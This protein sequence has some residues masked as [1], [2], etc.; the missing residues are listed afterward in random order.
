M[1]PADIEARIERARALMRACTLCERRCG[2]D[3]LAGERGYCGLGAEARLVRELLHFGEELEL[4]PSHAIYL[5]GCSFRCVFC[6]S[7][8]VVL[9]QAAPRCG[10]ALEPQRFAQV[11]AARRAQGARNVNFLGG[12][13]SVNLL[14]VLELLRHCPPDTRVVWNSNMYYTP[15]QAELLDGVV[16]VYLGDWKFGNDACAMRLAAVP[17][18]TQV[19]RRNFERALVSGARVIA[20]YLVMPG[21]ERC[22]LEPICRMLAQQLPGVALS[23]LDPYLPLFRAGRVPGMDRASTP[24]EGERARALAA[25]YG[26][27]VVR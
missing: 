11:V 26:L 5:S 13:P 14:A 2:V 22:C 6:M 25:R 16:D 19:V 12:E 9:K 20:R 27:E 24:A 4:C 3:R 7:G 15:E 18:Y 23:V 10:V 8:P 1:V 17:A 21:H